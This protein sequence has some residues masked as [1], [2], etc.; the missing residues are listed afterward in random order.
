MKGENETLKE[1][2]KKKRD[3]NRK[4]SENQKAKTIADFS[5]LNEGE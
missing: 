2:R 5:T 4:L 3:H 1:K